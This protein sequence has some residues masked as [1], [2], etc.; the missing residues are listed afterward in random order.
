MKCLL[1]FSVLQA[2]AMSVQTKM[3]CT[4]RFALRPTVVHQAV[5]SRDSKQWHTPA[6]GQTEAWHQFCHYPKP[7]PMPLQPSD[8][9]T[10]LTLHVIVSCEHC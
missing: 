8:M 9:L 2:V 4:Q 6:A 3:S 10:A 7:A 5:Q 1:S